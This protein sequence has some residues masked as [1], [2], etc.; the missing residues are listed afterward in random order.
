MNASQSLGAESK[1]P[2]HPKRAQ[3]VGIYGAA[4]AAALALSSAT[5]WMAPGEAHAETTIAGDFDFAF[6]A[7]AGWADTGVGFGIRIG[8]ELHVPLLAIN[9]ELGFTYHTFGTGSGN[10]ST[11]DP[12][13]YRGI[14]GLRL[15]LGE[16]FRVG[17][18]GHLGVGRLDANINLRDV[19]HTAFTWD[20]GLFL[21][22]TVLPLLNVGVHTA[23][24]KVASN[25]EKNALQW[26][27]LGAHAALVF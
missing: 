13:V 12:S 11:N 18:S 2:G 16:I 19:S 4:F 5:L 23:Y 26:Y 10:L 6:P 8:Q 14:A 7:S 1:T 24:T 22:L 20:M 21:D 3:R 17:V 27:T 15:G 9:P 25:D